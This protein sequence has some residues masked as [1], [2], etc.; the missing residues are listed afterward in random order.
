[1]GAVKIANFGNKFVPHIKFGKIRN[2]DSPQYGLY[3]DISAPINVKFIY[4]G[5]MSP[6]GAK[7]HFLTE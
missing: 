7:T 6:C 3:S 5:N 2:F 1:M 4:R